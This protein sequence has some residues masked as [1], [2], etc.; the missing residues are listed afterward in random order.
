[1]SLIDA[2]KD[3][4]AGSKKPRALAIRDLVNEAKQRVADIEAQ[5]GDR[6]LA[7]AEGGEEA[8]TAM[9]AWRKS[10]L[11][12]QENVRDLEAAAEAQKEVDRLAE[13]HRTAETRAT[14]VRS[15][16]QKL[17]EQ[18]KHLARLGAA[19]ENASTEW[20]A[21]IHCAHD[22]QQSLSVSQIKVPDNLVLPYDGLLRKAVLAELWRCNV[23]PATE[24][25]N[26]YP[27]ALPGVQEAEFERRGMAIAQGWKDL[28]DG[29]RSKVI[30]MVQRLDA[31][32]QILTAA[33]EADTLPPAGVVLPKELPTL[34]EPQLA[35]IYDP[36]ISTDSDPSKWRYPDDRP[37][38]D[39]ARVTGLSPEFD[40]GVIPEEERKARKERGRI[41]DQKA[42]DTLAYL[43]RAMTESAKSRL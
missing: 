42:A 16:K 39:T 33:M 23:T 40:D 5:R 12:A 8:K 7:L 19:I 21:V 10:L 35:P 2:L 28:E 24:P 38:I 4:L 26:I 31:E 3:R 41:A 32:R 15:L 13:R 20:A 27:A 34:P 14:H 30:P 6:I 17:S 11:D 18:A 1:M 36:S 22:I 29:F 25:G 37:T 43:E 9:A